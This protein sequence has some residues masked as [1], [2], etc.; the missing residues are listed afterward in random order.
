M[1][2][3]VKNEERIAK[4]V[5]RLKLKKIY[6]IEIWNKKV[7]RQRRHTACIHIDWKY[8][9]ASEG[10]LCKTIDSLRSFSNE[11]DP[12]GECYIFYK[13]V[14]EYGTGDVIG[15]SVTLNKIREKLKNI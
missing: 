15:F 11:V 13:T 5:I 7:S 12:K 9:T 14:K 4:F 8:L 1:L 3:E 2:I 10:R 6:I